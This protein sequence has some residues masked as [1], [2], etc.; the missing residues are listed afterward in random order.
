MTP[1]PRLRCARSAPGVPLVGA[2]ALQALP[3]LTGRALELRRQCQQALPYSPLNDRALAPF[4]VQLLGCPSVGNSIGDQR[5]GRGHPR[6]RKLPAEATDGNDVAGE[7]LEL[8]SLLRGRQPRFR[9]PDGGRVLRR[10]SGP[11]RWCSD[12]RLRFLQ[13]RLE[14]PVPELPLRRSSSAKIVL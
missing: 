7:P 14:L 3:R 12:S 9:S 5:S 1:S 6:R 10:A 11:L 8:H 2:H 13:R 4:G